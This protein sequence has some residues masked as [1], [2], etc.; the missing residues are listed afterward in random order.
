MKNIYYVA[1]LGVTVGFQMNSYVVMEQD[2]SLSVCIVV[3][4]A[5]SEAQTRS[6]SVLVETISDTASG[7]IISVNSL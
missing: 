6:I 4:S 2:E 5:G 3:V 7:M 1:L